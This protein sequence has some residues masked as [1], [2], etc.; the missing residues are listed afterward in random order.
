[1]AGI[2]YTQLKELNLKYPTLSQEQ[3][4][5]LSKAKTMLENE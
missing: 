4:Q 1:V 5:E 2:I 3:H